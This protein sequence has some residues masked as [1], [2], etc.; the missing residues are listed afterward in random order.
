M[1]LSERSGS[2]AVIH[3][4]VSAMDDHLARGWEVMDVIEVGEHE[5]VARLRR[6]LRDCAPGGRENE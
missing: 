5:P 6:P 3:V 2:F 1:D 4:V